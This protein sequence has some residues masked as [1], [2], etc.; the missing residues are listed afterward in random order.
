M[1]ETGPIDPAALDK[2]LAVI[3]G[4]A[5]DLQELIGDFTGIA[6]DL[7]DTIRSG[8]AAADWDAV[9]IAAVATLCQTLEQ[10]LKDGGVAE[11]RPLLEHL[12]SAI[13][14]AVAALDA[15]GRRDA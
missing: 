2:L 6:V 15:L 12:D 7:N 3:G 10:E 8:V 13:A 14:E 9:R 11:P 4:D 5:E 1:T